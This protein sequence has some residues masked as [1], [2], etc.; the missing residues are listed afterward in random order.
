MAC[1]AN[2]PIGP[3]HG[4]HEPIR[5]GEYLSRVNRAQEIERAAGRRAALMAAGET[6]RQRPDVPAA[7][8]APR[9]GEVRPVQGPYNSPIRETPRVTIQQLLPMGSIIDVTI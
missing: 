7:Q 8:R 1:P 4:V 3:C 5:F 2:S 6:S 9:L